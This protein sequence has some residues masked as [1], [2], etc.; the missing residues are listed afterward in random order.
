MKSENVQ[1]VM[2]AGRWLLD[3]GEIT[4]VDERETL[5]EAQ[6]RAEA[7]ARRAKVRT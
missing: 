5:A 4:V 1:S 7:V 6:K 2:C 3:E